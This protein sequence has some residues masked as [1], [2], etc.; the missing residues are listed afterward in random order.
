M[1]SRT[2]MSLCGAL[3]AFMGATIAPSSMGLAPASAAEK[4]RVGVPSFGPGRWEMY[5]IERHGLARLE[6][7][8]LEVVALGSKL[9]HAIAMEEDVADIVLSDYFWASAERRHGSDY[10]FVPHS[11]MAGGVIARPEPG[12]NSLADLNGR[13]IGILGGPTEDS[14]VLLRA[15]TRKKM[16]WDIADAAG[17]VMFVQAPSVLNDSITRGL[18]DAMLNDW[19]YNALLR[20]QGYKD[21]LSIGDIIST[22]GLDD[23]PPVLGWVFSERW[24][25][26]HAD[27]VLGYLR[28]SLAAK[29]IL[30]NSDE[31]WE[32][33][34][35][36][37]RAE[38]DDDK[39]LALRDAYRETIATSYG[40]EQRVAV[41]QFLSIL[42]R[43]GGPSI[44]GRAEALAPGT[45][46]SI[47]DGPRPNACSDRCT[48]DGRR[49]Q[50]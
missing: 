16:G 8:N 13:I 23:H 40:T 25:N 12:I 43:E 6:G 21:L 30:L 29:R 50:C 3:A 39:F 4:V 49:C 42:R 1:T 2:F 11:K 19:H 18:V 14:W 5:T 10:T 15:Y 9:T 48:W 7:L 46:Y 31:E 28:A 38:D 24:A 41:E 37:M 33:L 47:T 27:V 36:A 44:F 20:A 35:A 22:L 34:R 45:F 32:H 17:E 26:E